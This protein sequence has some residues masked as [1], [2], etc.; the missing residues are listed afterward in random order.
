MFVAVGAAKWSIPNM[1]IKKLEYG[2][3]RRSKDKDRCILIYAHQWW[4]QKEK[5]KNT[6][7]WKHYKMFIR[8]S[9]SINI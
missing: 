2:N 5:K 6:Y 7:L 8:L 3:P 1:N 9:S 4:P